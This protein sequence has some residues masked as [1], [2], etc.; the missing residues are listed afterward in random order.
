MAQGDREVVTRPVVTEGEG[1]G[2]EGGAEGRT[3]SITR[4]SCFEE[5]VKVRMD[6]S[7]NKNVAVAP[8]FSRTSY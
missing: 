4:L 7:K 1:E 6:T 5:D 2:L 3:S 8:L